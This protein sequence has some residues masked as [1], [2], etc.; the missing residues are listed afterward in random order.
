MNIRLNSFIQPS[1]KGF[2]AVPQE[3]EAFV[4]HNLKVQGF[5]YGGTGRISTTNDSTSNRENLEKLLDNNIP[6]V[7]STCTP[8]D[9]ADALS[10][11]IDPKLISH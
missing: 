8:I 2:F 4:R 10:I 11:N 9:T 7:F 3:K 6:F 1:F 5:Y